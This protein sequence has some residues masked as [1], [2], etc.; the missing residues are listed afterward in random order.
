MSVLEHFDSDA[1][2]AG[3]SEDIGP[4]ACG[5]Q[6]DVSSQVE[7]LRL[8]SAEDSV[9]SVGQSG[10]GGQNS[11]IFACNLEFLQLRNLEFSKLNSY[12]QWPLWNR[13]YRCKVKTGVA[14][15]RKRQ[16][17]PVKGLFALQ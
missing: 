16:H 11:K 15:A 9:T 6:N 17:N 1:H 13:H 14:W 4:T 12:R 10:I 2:Q 3:Q 5:S 7:K 8:G